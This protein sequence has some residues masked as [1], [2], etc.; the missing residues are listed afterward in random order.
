MLAEVSVV[1]S[2]LYS[3]LWCV[4]L[5]VIINIIRKFK[6][7]FWNRRWKLFEEINATI[8]LNETCYFVQLSCFFSL[9][10]KKVMYSVSVHF[11]S[12]FLPRIWMTW[13]LSIVI[14]VVINEVLY[15]HNR[16]LYKCRVLDNGSCHLCQSISRHRTQISVNLC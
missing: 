5:Y 9:I 7:T 4:S 14:T 10:E 15:S 6:K 12:K 11:I 2:C 16:R 13:D 8:H 1:V 3:S